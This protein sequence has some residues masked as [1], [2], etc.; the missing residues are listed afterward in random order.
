[1][2]AGHNLPTMAGL[3]AADA[4]E[5]HRPL[6]R[7]KLLNKSQCAALL[8]QTLV[9]LFFQRVDAAKAAALICNRNPMY[10][11]WAANGGVLKSRRTTNSAGKKGAW[12]IPDPYSFEPE[13]DRP[14]GDRQQAELQA[15]LP[16]ELV[17]TLP[18][19]V[20]P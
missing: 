16:F 12:T 4:R 20:L 18:Y 7:I 13:S 10:C 6:V 2:S 19:T 5:A 9:Q 15:E 17:A 8:Q 14:L 3:F 1:M 11:D